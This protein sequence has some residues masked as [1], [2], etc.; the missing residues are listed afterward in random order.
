MFTDVESALVERLKAEL[1]DVHVLTAMEL[2]EIEEDRQPTPAVHVIYNGYQVTESPRPDGKT[3]RISQ[4]WLTVIAVRNLRG[5][6]KNDAARQDAIPL[7]QTLAGSLMG[8]QPLPKDAGPMRLETAP[9]PGGQN[10]FL[11]VP[12]AWSVE[13]VLKAN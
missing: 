3:V 4:R 7:A 9:V 6:G 8:F 12:L 2:S 1:P 11:Y 5:R 10:G 13:T